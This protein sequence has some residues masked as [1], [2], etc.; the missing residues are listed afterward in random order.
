[1]KHRKTC[2]L[3]VLAALFVPVIASAAL[4]VENNTASLAN[5]ASVSQAEVQS[6]NAWF[7][8]DQSSDGYQNSG[9]LKT[10]NALGGQAQA[11]GSLAAGQALAATD[12]GISAAIAQY[13]GLYQSYYSDYL[14]YLDDANAAASKYSACVASGGK[15][16][17]NQAGY[18]N[19]L[20]QQA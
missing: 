2:R 3:A 16:C 11:Q 8:S 4:D 9:Q 14:N 7:N 5:D 13:L 12:P 10:G 17:L 20:A 6:G 15:T 19:G 18:Y 1:M